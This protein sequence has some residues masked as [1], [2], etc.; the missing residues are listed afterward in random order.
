[1]GGTRGAPAQAVLLSQVPE[2]G[3]RLVLSLNEGGTGATVTGSAHGLA[4]PM[5]TL[6]PSNHTSYC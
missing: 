6:L 1:M 3:H 2:G 5:E 4:V